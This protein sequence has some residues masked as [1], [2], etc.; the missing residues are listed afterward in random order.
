[1]KTPIYLV[2]KYIPDLS[3]MEPRNIGIVLWAAQKSYCR[4]LP[5]SEAANIV[6]DMS[7][8]TRWIDFWTLLVREGTVNLPRERSVSVAS[9]EYLT[10]LKRTQKENYA[11][12]DGGEVMSPIKP[13]KGQEVA[14]FLFQQ[15]VASTPAKD[16]GHEESLATAAGALLEKAGVTERS[17]FYRSHEIECDYNG[18]AEPLRFHYYLGNGAPEAVLH[19]AKITSSVSV[20]STAWMFD[21][22]SAAYPAAKRGVIVN[23][24]DVEAGERTT[25][26]FLSVLDRLATTIDLASEKTALARLRSIV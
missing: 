22:L 5:A 3:R 23:T 1:M 11:L 10:A 21:R 24:A 7:V 17:D 25:R 12:D 6:R 14:D 4:F 18:I 26:A 20:N 19:R 9:P 16:G 8:Y 13:G 2:A 15:L